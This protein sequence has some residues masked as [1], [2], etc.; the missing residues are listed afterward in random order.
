MNTLAYD[1]LCSALPPGMHNSPVDFRVINI[2]DLTKTYAVD[3]RLP[4][5]KKVFYKISLIKGRNRA[6]YADKVIRINDQALL[7]ATPRI[8][9]HWIPLDTQQSGMF[10]V[11]TEE[12]MQKG[13]GG[14]LL[15]SLPIFRQG[16]LPVFELNAQDVADIEYTFHRME[17]EMNS[18]YAY[19]DDLLR[20]LVVDLIHLGQ[21]L[22]P[23]PVERSVRNAANRISQLFLE[24]L[25]RQFPI[26]STNQRLT[27]RTA[28]DFALWLSVHVNHLN[29]ALK[30]T[31][32]RTTSAIISARILS[33]SKT[34]LTNTSWSIAEIAYSLG[35][36]E[37]S[38]FST[39]FK[40]Q[41]G[42]SPAG[43]R[44]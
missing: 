5:S 39:F 15:D 11:F 30:E 17:R 21:K 18:D 29:R 7:F 38:Y 2:D 20:N 36:E 6:E 41:T 44:G 12:F 40:K 22:Q 26:G 27:L 28:K 14:I 43:F 24:L 35:F 31:T 33:E 4:Y 10:C 3:G 13:N 37:A 16:G 8:P 32:G 25:E 19:R 1:Q 34:L 23:A 42:L 9:Y